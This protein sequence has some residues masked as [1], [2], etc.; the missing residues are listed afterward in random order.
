[1]TIVNKSIPTKLGT[2][3]A[4]AMLLGGCATTAGNSGPQDPID[5]LARSVTDVGSRVWDG[6][7]YLFKLKEGDTLAENEYDEYPDE[8]DLALIDVEEFEKLDTYDADAAQPEAVEELA[9]IE[10]ETTP[11]LPSGDT[12]LEETA[13]LAEETA[14]PSL[15]NSAEDLF[16]TVG[17]NE[18][19]W[20]LAKMLTGN[21][22]NWRQLAELNDL[23]ENG[24][25]KIGQQL[26]IPAALKKVPLDGE[27]TTAVAEQAPKATQEQ[28]VVAA[29]SSD[30]PSET[31][32]VNA[33]ESMWVLSKRTTGNAANW[34]T[35][36][37]F[38]GMDE[39]AANHIR[40][41]QKL[42]I[43]S[44][45][46]SNGV[47]GDTVASGK[48]DLV[49]SKEEAANAVAKAIAPSQKTP[50]VDAGTTDGERQ[51]EVAEQA[52]ETTQVVEVPANFKAEPPTDLPT[53]AKQAGETH[54]LAQQPAP[55]AGLQEGEIMVSG[56]YYPKAIYNEANFSSSLLM[57]VSPG[58]RLRVS[59][60][61]G[62]WYEVETD[63]GTGFVH[64]RDTN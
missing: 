24:T 7:R 56:T 1:M 41:G 28:P 15:D 35:I 4:S 58:T 51:L 46:L 44:K 25:L 62:P 37:N 16:H 13:E 5:R 20:V 61:I 33:G 27:Q 9:A 12:V 40:Y 32:T 23:D 49:P 22:N 39:R 43:P 14:K 30:E 2:V 45:L 38:N 3:L 34:L 55:A 21:A 26:R 29:A 36:A 19:L 42:Q 54:V 17:E 10:P 48:D 52:S 50:G 18:S 60:T 31:F 11:L 6:T 8:V 47:S 64:S 53:E 59:Q 63:Q 57:R